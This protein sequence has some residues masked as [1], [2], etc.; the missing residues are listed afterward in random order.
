MLSHKINVVI[1][2]F[3]H[4]PDINCLM[5]T[6]GY[7]FRQLACFTYTIIAFRIQVRNKI[8]EDHPERAGQGTGFTAGAAHLIALQ[9]PV[10]GA[11]QG[12][13]ITGFYAG[14]LFAMPADS[15]EGRVFAQSRHSVI[16]RVIK[17]LTVR[18]AILT[19]ITDIQIY[20]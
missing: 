9:V 17:I 12:I 11:L 3:L 7:A 15:G 18:A 4:F 16:L 5:R 2:A 6:T 19:A 14:G 1:R 13:M 10:A 8:N 20:E